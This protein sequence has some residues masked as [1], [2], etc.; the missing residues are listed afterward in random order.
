M[1]FAIDGGFQVGVP[2]ATSAYSQLSRPLLCN[3]MQCLVNVY[4]NS[5][6]GCNAYHNNT[7]VWL[8]P[9]SFFEMGLL[10]FVICCI[11]RSSAVKLWWTHDLTELI[12]FWYFGRGCWNPIWEQATFFTAAW[13]KHWNTWLYDFFPK[14]WFG[15][16]FFVSLFFFAVQ[17]Y[18][19]S[20]CQR[21]LFKQ[22]LQHCF[23]FLA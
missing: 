3:P 4:G 20:A 6:W 10:L 19:F 21:C 17:F 5:L 14:R 12:T 7:S 18:R 23:V 11:L 1:Q 8:L 16:I 22:W 15:R 13:F 9:Q 2:L